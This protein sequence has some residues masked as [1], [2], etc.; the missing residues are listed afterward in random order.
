MLVS[1]RPE[2]S[3]TPYDIGSVNQTNSAYQYQKHFLFSLFYFGFRFSI[4][5]NHSVL[6]NLHKIMQKE[7][8]TY[9]YV[10]SVGDSAGCLLL[11]AIAL[12][13]AFLLLLIGGSP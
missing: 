9:C 11:S 10:K 6:I 12:D 2:R 4:W 8:V 7:C 13:A 5:V 3:S 1:R